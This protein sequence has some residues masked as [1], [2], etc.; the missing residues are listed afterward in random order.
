MMNYANILH[1]TEIFLGWNGGKE[2]VWGG[3]T[4]K[5]TS[6]SMQLKYNSVKEI[7]FDAA[8]SV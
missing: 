8:S 5:L 2:E 1:L 6:F 3:M 4:R 7:I